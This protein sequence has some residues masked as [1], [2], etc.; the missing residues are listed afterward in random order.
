MKVLRWIVFVACLLWA[1][2]GAIVMMGYGAGSSVADLALSA[3]IN[4]G[5]LVLSLAWILFTAQR[6]RN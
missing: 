4:F 6:T 2:G 1:M 3:L 5:P